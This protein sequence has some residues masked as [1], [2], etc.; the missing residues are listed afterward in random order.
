LGV[1]AVGRLILAGREL[2]RLAGFTARVDELCTV[3]SDL[4]EDK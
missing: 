4:Q 1:Q 3:L 2:T